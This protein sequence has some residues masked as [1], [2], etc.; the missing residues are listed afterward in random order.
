ML[1]VTLDKFQ[2]R[3]RGFEIFPP[4]LFRDFEHGPAEIQADDF[5]AAP[6]ERQRQIAGAA[7][8]VQRAVARFHCRQFNDAVF[9][10]AVKAETLQVIQQVITPGNR[11]EEVIDLRGALFARGK[12]DVAHGLILADWPAPKSKPIN[13]GLRSWLFLVQT[14]LATQV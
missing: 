5:R 6:C 9:P 13:S 1:R 8:Q 4:P 14:L 2:I 12:K 10:A 3:D 11:G 7:A